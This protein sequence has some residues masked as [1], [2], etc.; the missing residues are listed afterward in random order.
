MRFLVENLPYY[1]NY[2]PFMDDCLEKD[3]V[4]CP[5]AWGKEFVCSDEN[6]HCCC[7]LRELEDVIRGR[8]R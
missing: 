4:Y 8:V 1:N 7:R 6:P 5:R 2:C 3:G